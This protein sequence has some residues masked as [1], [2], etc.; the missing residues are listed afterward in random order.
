MNMLERARWKRCPWC[1][2]SAGHSCTTPFG[3]LLEV[4]HQARID[5]PEPPAQPNRKS[6]V[7]YADV[8]DLFNY[9][10]HDDQASGS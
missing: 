10:D 3:K 9:R 2:A 1:H 6:L 4:L 8:I 5:A 7:A